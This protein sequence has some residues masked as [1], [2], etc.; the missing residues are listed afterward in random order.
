M[1]QMGLCQKCGET[2][3]VQD[4]HILGYNEDNKDYVVKYCNS[5]D[6]KAHLKARKEGKC[7]LTH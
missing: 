1:K 3:I 7:N 6:Q 5:C 4:H 2:K